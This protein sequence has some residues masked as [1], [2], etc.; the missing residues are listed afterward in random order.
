MYAQNLYKSGCRQTEETVV[1]R[2]LLLNSADQSI[3]G[4]QIGLKFVVLITIFTTAPAANCS[5]S[6]LYGL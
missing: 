1:M 2:G 6:L 3:Y 5:L 4:A